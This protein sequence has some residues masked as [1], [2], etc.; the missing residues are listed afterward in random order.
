MKKSLTSDKYTKL[1]KTASISLLSAATLAA[2]KVLTYKLE[3]K[4]DK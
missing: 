2:V 1:L 3:T 4:E